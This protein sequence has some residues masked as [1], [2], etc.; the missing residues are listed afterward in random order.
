MRDDLK[1]LISDAFPPVGRPSRITVHVEG[2]YQCSWAIEELRLEQGSLL[3]DEAVRWLLGELSV[4][5]AEGFRWV[6]PSYLNA[7][8]GDGSNI[9]LGEFLA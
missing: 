3:G 4:L 1:K 5:S 2:C 9:D 8:V 6:L 7:I